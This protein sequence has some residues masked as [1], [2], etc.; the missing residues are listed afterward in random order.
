MEATSE[1]DA[2]VIAT[3]PAGTSVSSVEGKEVT[4]ASV[5]AAVA[6]AAEDEAKNGPIVSIFSGFSVVVN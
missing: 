1:S 3:S 4:M 5:T 6:D 2:V